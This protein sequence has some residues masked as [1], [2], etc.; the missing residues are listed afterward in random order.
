MGK[1]MEFSSIYPYGEEQKQPPNRSSHRRSS[2]KYSVL[3]NFAKF[4]GKHLCQSLFFNKVA[5][6]RHRHRY[7][8]V[9]FA[10]FGRTPFFTEHPWTT[11]SGRTLQLSK[12]TKMLHCQKLFLSPK[13]DFYANEIENVTLK[14]NLKWY[15]MTF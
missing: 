4:P 3:I 12:R 14:T 5:G 10:K 7:F 1:T 6:L 2:K 13:L 11:T 8:S 15:S 9:N